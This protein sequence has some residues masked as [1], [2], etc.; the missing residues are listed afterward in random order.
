MT[1]KGK[2]VS[3]ETKVATAIG[4]RSGRRYRRGDTFV[5]PVSD[6]AKWFAPQGSD[7]AKDAL[8]G[9]ASV[10]EMPASELKAHVKTMTSAA[11]NDAIG[12][13]QG[14]TR[15]RNI[16]NIL[17]SEL[18]DRVGQLGGPDPAAKEPEEKDPLIPGGE[19]PALK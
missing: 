9:K 10:L 19:D 18:E 12:A 13:E 2:T 8:S 6:T 14:G 3:T 16:L 15:R 17:Q 1:S 4:F 11:I 7:E 5:A